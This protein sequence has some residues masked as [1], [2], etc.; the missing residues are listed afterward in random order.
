MEDMIL[1]L[2][3]ELDSMAIEIWGRPVPQGD[4]CVCHGKPVDFQ[5]FRDDLSRKEYRISKLCQEGQDD[6]FGVEE[7]EG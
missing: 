6:F 3:M 4:F 7:E 5:A 1:N 2:K